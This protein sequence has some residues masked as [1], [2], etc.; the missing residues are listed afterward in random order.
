MHKKNLYVAKTLFGFE[1]ILADELN[2]LNCSDVKVLNRAVTFSGDKKTL[3]RVNLRSRLSLNIL[4]EWANFWT[5]NEDDFYK[6]VKK[7][8]WNEV[9]SPEKTFM[10]KT[11]IPKSKVF[12]HSQFIGLRAKDA[13]ADYFTESMGKRPNVDTVDPDVKIQVYINGNKCSISLDSSGEALFK[14]GY[15]TNTGFAPINEVLAAG[16]IALSG[17]H[18]QTTFYDPMCGSGTFLI[19]AA[20]IAHNIPPGMKRRFG[21]QNWINYTPA[22]WQQVFKEES[23]KVTDTQIDI[24]GSDTKQVNLEIARENITNAFLEDSIRV[25]KKDFFTS[26]WNKNEPPHMVFNPPY[27]KRLEEND[28]IAFYKKIGDTLKFG[29]SGAEAWIISANVDAMK[30]IGLRPSKKIKLFN[31]PL[32]CKLQQYK[33]YRGSKAELHTNK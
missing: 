10:I 1:N 32:E 33:M 24:I 5:R 18:G 31:G 29:Y 16:I 23:E 20:M 17:W 11:N 6:Q 12:Q 7:L 14:R 4:M 21:F 30:F 2:S 9:L 13:I 27:N 25:S 15:R 28:V 26:E 3:Y 19:E 22:L 8:P